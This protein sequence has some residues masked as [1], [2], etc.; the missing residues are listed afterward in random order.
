MPLESFGNGEERPEFLPEE[1]LAARLKAVQDAERFTYRGPDISIEFAH[2]LIG[3]IHRK[4]PNVMDKELR[5]INLSRDGYMA[6]FRL[7]DD[8]AHRMDTESSF[9]DGGPVPIV[10]RTKAP[11]KAPRKKRGK[12]AATVAAPTGHANDDPPSTPVAGAPAPSIAPI[13]P[14]PNRDETTIKP[15]VAELAAPDPAWIERMTTLAK[16]MSDETRV[17]VMV[18]LSNLTEGKRINVSTM[19]RR[20]N[21]SQ[22]AL[23][24]HISL[25][26]DAG[27]LALDRDGGRQNFYRV[28]QRF[29]DDMRAVGNFLDG[30]IARGGAQ[31]E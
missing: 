12:T 25:L 10:N 8:I 11:P 29:R 31:N 16:M 20:L 27:F 18:T 9:R 19:A 23:S 13:D 26:E 3:K 22:P 28:T 15:P 2:G 6:I 5:A 1:Q 21:M 14:A 4:A 17:Q 30:T 24:H 7:S